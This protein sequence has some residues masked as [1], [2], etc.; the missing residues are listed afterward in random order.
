MHTKPSK[1]KRSMRPNYSAMYGLLMDQ[2]GALTMWGSALVSL[3]SIGML[4]VAWNQ[5]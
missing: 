2:V 1:S 4:F 3:E 5:T